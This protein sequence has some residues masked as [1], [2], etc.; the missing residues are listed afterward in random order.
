MPPAYS[1]L[2]H[3]IQASWA[4]RTQGHLEISLEQWA[5]NQSSPPKG[6]QAN[7]PAQKPW[8][9][10]TH[11]LLC[12]HRLL[13]PHNFNFFTQPVEYPWLQRGRAIPGLRIRT[14]L[15]PS[16]SLTFPGW[17]WPVRSQGRSAWEQVG[18]SWQRHVKGKGSGSFPAPSWNVEAEVMPVGVA[19]WGP[20]VTAGRMVTDRKSLRFW[21]CHSSTSRPTAAAADV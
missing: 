7:V 6:K 5:P 16:N 13:C 3:R 14:E 17:F 10:H 12:P 20:K 19:A 9:L 15:K 18:R 21:W 4:S 8:P 11:N 1:W 2:C